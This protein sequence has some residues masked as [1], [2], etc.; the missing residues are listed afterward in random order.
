MAPWTTPIFLQARIIKNYA[1]EPL[2]IYTQPLYILL[3]HP[4]VVTL[5]SSYFV[6]QICKID[7]AHRA[8][9]MHNTSK[10]QLL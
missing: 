1:F 5:T 6:M 7:T 10:L 2:V 3:R 4:S 8:L 9:I